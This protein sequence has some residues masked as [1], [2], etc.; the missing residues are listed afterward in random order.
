MARP[1]L[2]DAADPS[3]VVTLIAT[4]RRKWSVPDPGKAPTP[5]RRAGAV[6]IGGFLDMT[7][8]ERKTILAPWLA[9]QGLALVYAQRGVGKTFFAMNVAHAIAMCVERR[10][11][12]AHRRRAREC[13]VSGVYSPSGPGGRFGHS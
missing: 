10:G 8:P 6:G 7:L 4:A 2:D 13:R 11:E 5:E 9:D 1:Y 12:I 3:D